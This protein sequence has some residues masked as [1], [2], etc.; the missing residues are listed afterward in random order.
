MKRIALIIAGILFTAIATG[1]IWLNTSVYGRIYLPSGTG[2]T[3]KQLCSLQWVSGLSQE[4][5][6]ALYLDPL[7]GDVADLLSVHVDAEVKEVRTSIF[8][9]WRQ[10][11]IYRDGLGCTLV[12]D[13]NQFDAELSLPPARAH[14]PLTL[15]A[16][17]RDAHF[18]TN[19]LHAA[20]ADAFAE[21]INTLAVAVLHEGRLV[22][23]AYATDISADSPL[24]G[25][26]MTKSAMATLAGV[27][28]ERGE[29]DMFAEGRITE[30]MEV[31][32]SYADVTLDSLLRM[33]GGFAIAETN[34]GTDPNSDMLFTEADMPRFAATRERLH[35]PG[36]H[37]QY[38]SG[39]TILATRTMQDELG[40]TVADQ[41]AGLRERLFEPLGIYSAIMELDQTGTF[42]GSSY[43]Y[44]TAHDWARLAQFQLDTVSPDGEIRLPDG[45]YDYVATPTPTSDGMYGVGFWTNDDGLPDNT[46]RMSGFQGQWAYII[47]SHD[48]VVVRLGATN[49]R[50]DRARNLAGA[51]LEAM[52]EEE[53]AIDVQA[54]DA[55]EPQ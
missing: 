54:E 17:H 19:M 4:R 38:M 33:A 10:H 26:S 55:A 20:I 11:A 27:M 18:D 35:P 31:D 30:L 52:R 50:N 44:A 25:W 15:N 51:V 49:Y 48:L 41:V 5:A 53:A 42:Q 3:A 47:P 6:R 14:Q 40:D 22:A 13:A 16:D 32:P 24:H 7:L 43:M 39:N 8:G 9:L 23:D 36:A 28:V 37:W 1:L 34:T 21:P 29:V 46:V 12:H 45:W 2:I